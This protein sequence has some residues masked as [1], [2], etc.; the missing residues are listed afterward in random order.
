MQ[1][2]RDAPPAP[3]NSTIDYFPHGP[4]GRFVYVAGF[5]LVAL[6]A[7]W[8]MTYLGLT[9]IRVHCTRAERACSIRTTRPISGTTWTWIALSKIDDVASRL[10]DGKNPDYHVVLYLKHGD[11]DLGGHWSATDAQQIVDAL[12]DFFETSDEPEVDILTNPSRP[13]VAAFYALIGIGSL[14]FGFSFLQTA[15][16]EVIWRQ[17]IFRVIRNRWPLPSRGKDF[18][19][20]DVRG[21]YVTE[22]GSKRRPVFGVSLRVEGEVDIRLPGDRTPL[23]EPKRR[24]VNKLEELLRLRDAGGPTNSNS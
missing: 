14:A 5:G 15:R 20:D 9:E 17:R 23:D 13:G 3:A 22:A 1:A 12:K 2:Y 19:L 11:E 8:L 16:I 6:I 24:F 7:F 18:P 10:S 21:A 4:R